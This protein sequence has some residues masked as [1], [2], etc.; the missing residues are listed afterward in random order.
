[1]TVLLNPDNLMRANADAATMF[2]SDRRGFIKYGAIFAAALGF[3]TPDMVQAAPTTAARGRE[4][5]LLNAHTGET[6]KGEYWYNGRYQPDA[7]REIKSV[8]RDYRTNDQF[9]IDPR[10]MDVLFVL[11]H[12]LGVRSKDLRV[13]SGYRSPRTNAALRRSTSGVARQSLH[14]QGQAIDF[15]IPGISLKNVRKVA[16]GLHAGGVGYYPKSDF[17]HIDTGRVRSWG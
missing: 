17:V 9:P 1:M 7:F 3:W 15:Q 13:F 10:L 11:Q 5:K 2:E 6:F 12:R 16:I 14:M 8:M 4:L